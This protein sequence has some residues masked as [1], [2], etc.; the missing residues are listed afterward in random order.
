[1]VTRGA[2]AYFKSRLQSGRP[3]TYQPYK[4]GKAF[5]SVCELVSV[6]GLRSGW[7]QRRE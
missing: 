2:R 3:V 4:F 7:S 6:S 5:L 1:M